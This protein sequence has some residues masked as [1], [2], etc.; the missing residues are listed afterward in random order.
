MR[1]AARRMVQERA[2]CPVA[3]ATRGQQELTVARQI[4]REVIQPPIGVMIDATRSIEEIQT[5]IADVLLE[6][7][8]KA[9]RCF[10]TYGCDDPIHCAPRRTGECEW[11]Q[12]LS[13]RPR[14]T[15]ALAA[16]KG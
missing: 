3:E 4:F 8:L 11:A 2:A 14:P 6:G 10:K 13:I 5:A 9:K 7:V 15:Q 1:P 12:L 16:S